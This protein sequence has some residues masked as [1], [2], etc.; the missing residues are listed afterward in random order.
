MPNQKDYHREQEPKQEEINEV[1]ANSFSLNYGAF[2]VLL[3]FGLRNS[4]DP[5]V[6]K[7]RVH[8]SMEHAWV[9]VKLIDRGFQEYRQHGGKFTIPL[10]VLNQLGL[11]EEYRE[12]FGDKK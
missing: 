5:P 1:Y 2:D 10:E 3:D 9:M 12:D 11:T 4:D 6:I 7:A 8:M